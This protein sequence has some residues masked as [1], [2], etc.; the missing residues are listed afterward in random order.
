MIGENI[1]QY[2]ILNE[3]GRGGMATV[4]LAHDQGLDTNVAIKVLNKEFVHNDNIRKRFL[5]EARS[6]SMMSHPGIVRVFNSIEEH[7]IVAFVMEYVHGE[8]LG[9]FLE[10]RG[11]LNDDEIKVVFSQMIEAVGYVHELNLVHRDIKP[12]NFMIDKNGML[13][14]MDFGIAKTLD[15]SSSEYTQTG[16]GMQMGTPMYMSPEQVKSSKDVGPASDFYSLGV[17]LWQMVTGSKP[18]NTKTLSIFQLQTKIVN[19]PL[20]E[21][22][23]RWDKLITHLT[24]KTESKRPKSVVQIMSLLN[25]VFKKQDSGDDLTIVDSAANPRDLFKSHQ[26]LPAKYHEDAKSRK[27]LSSQNNSTL[28]DICVYLSLPVTGNKSELI[29]RITT[30]LQLPDES[31]DEIVARVYETYPTELVSSASLGMETQSW[32]TMICDEL[33]IDNK[34]TKKQLVDR[35][36]EALDIRIQ[37]LNMVV[38]RLSKRYQTELSDMESLRRESNFFIRYICEELQI[39]T[40][41]TKDEMLKKVALIFWPDEIETDAM[42]YYSREEVEQTLVDTPIMAKKP[43]EIQTIRTEVENA[44]V[45]SSSSSSKQ[46]SAGGCFSSFMSALVWIPFLALTLQ[47]LKRWL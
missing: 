43:S 39:D 27:S 13:K 23:T 36:V 25:L 4:Y 17:V 21:T 34:G 41:G 28:K 6:L 10:Q 1:L 35:I 31:H 22:H 24:Q 42:D 46:T 16:T 19:D 30:R 5:A 18:Y 15:I 44:H 7:H 11:K 45:N 47:F 38:D 3:L 37:P 32:L 29:D 26:S 14:L 2:K 12:S 9:Y 20:A 40:S 33:G 8:T